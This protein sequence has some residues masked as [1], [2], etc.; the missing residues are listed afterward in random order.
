MEYPLEQIEIQ[1]DQ[2]IL[3]QIAKHFG[4]GNNPEEILEAMKKLAVGNVPACYKRFAN[5]KRK[6]AEKVL[7]LYIN[8]SNEQKELVY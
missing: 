4:E 3:N 8:L 2:N 1:A 6:Q 7:E 5:L